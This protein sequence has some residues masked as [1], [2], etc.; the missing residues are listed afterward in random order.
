M[1]ES[2]RLACLQAM[3][4]TVWRSREQKVV[5]SD[6]AADSRVQPPRPTESMAPSPAAVAASLPDQ[7]LK[8]ASEVMPTASDWPA[9]RAEVAACTRCPLAESRTQTVFGKGSETADW[10]IIGEAPGQQEDLQGQPFVG[11]A[12][13]LLD[14]MLKA[15]GL[16]PESVYIANIVKCRPPDN[17]NPNAEEAAACRTFLDRQTALLK[18]KLIL[19]LGKVA[20]H[21]LLS[22]DSPLGQLRQQVFYRDTVPVVVSYH[23]AY[24]LRRLLDKKKAWDDW[25][26]ALKTF[27]S[28]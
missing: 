19:A 11:P 16:S 27:R 13:K 12:G 24:L 17:R 20:A 23:P 2:D 10:L 4:I 6:G 7:M 15:A 14:E 3:G 5:R 21:N 1:N 9:L 26:F 25:Q 8:V 28:H 22:T 18:P